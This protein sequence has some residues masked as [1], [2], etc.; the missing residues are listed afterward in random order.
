MHRFVPFRDDSLGRWEDRAGIVSS[1]L[2]PDSMDGGFCG[3]GAQ[4]LVYPGSTHFYLSKVLSMRLG[5]GRNGRFS[6]GFPFWFA[7][8]FEPRV[9]MT[10][11][12]V[13]F[14]PNGKG[15]GEAFWRAP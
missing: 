6:E 7:R 5:C 8:L 12:R 11:N 3:D 15:G 1:G 13:I 2:D 4:G 10:I 14:D 9:E